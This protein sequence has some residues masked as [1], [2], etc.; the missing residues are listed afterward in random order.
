MLP[1]THAQFL[2]VFRDYNLAIWPAQVVAV[3]LGLA[4]LALPFARPAAAGRIVAAILSVMWLWNGVVYHG[5]FFSG[6]NKAA[7][8]FAG[9]FVLE[10]LLL[11]EAAHAGRLAF[12]SKRGAAAYTGIGLSL[13]ALVLYPLIGHLSGLAWPAAPTFGTAPCPLTIFTFGTLLLAGPS[14]PRRL[15]V[16]PALWSVIG[17]SAAFLLAVPQDWMLLASGI[18]AVPWLLA[19][20]GGGR[21]P[22]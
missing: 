12:P 3:V 18:V 17:G 20:R 15:L 10:G 21:E 4:A 1:F 19:M 9:L 11:A 22:R 16:V 8:L 14:V 2:D 5:L 7:W 13:Y 6:I